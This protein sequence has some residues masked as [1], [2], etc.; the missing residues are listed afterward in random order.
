MQQNQ[1]IGP[2]PNSSHSPNSS[3]NQSSMIKFNSSSENSKTNSLRHFQQSLLGSLPQTYSLSNSNTNA[4]N[5]LIVEEEVTDSFS[6]Q[7]G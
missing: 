2:I 5:L 6:E 4:S 3:L 7:L 1:T